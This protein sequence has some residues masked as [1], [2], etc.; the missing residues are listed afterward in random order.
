MRPSSG[1]GGRGCRRLLT[2]LGLFWG[3]VLPGPQAGTFSWTRPSSPH[4]CSAS[5]AGGSS[6]RS[7]CLSVA[8]P[9]EA[10]AGRGPWLCPFREC[11]SEPLS[12]LHS[13]LSVIFLEKTAMLPLKLLM[14]LTGVCLP[15][16]WAILPSGSR[17]LP[18]SS[19]VR[20]HAC[21]DAL[22][23]LSSH[24][25]QKR[26]KKRACGAFPSLPAPQLSPPAACTAQLSSSIRCSLL[27]WALRLI[28]AA[29]RGGA[30]VSSG[31]SP[32]A[33]QLLRLYSSSY[34]NKTDL[35]PPLPPSST[36]DSVLYHLLHV[37]ILSQNYFRY[38]R[39]KNQKDISGNGSSGSISG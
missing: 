13:S 31:A 9:P 25:S 30:R 7:S 1:T 24:G 10:T 36:V 3:F 26:E 4:C 19:A 32:W 20:A 15:R 27:W 33:A 12:T 39:P 14:P 22:L 6:G 17:E 28:A 16:P 5:R 38:W 35:S 18:P 23:T 29:A 34:E 37:Y 21:W 2:L 11:L 8:T